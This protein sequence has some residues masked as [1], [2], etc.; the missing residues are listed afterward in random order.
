M[1]NLYVRSTDGS[2]S[3]NGS[4]WALAKATITGAAAIDVAGDSI[5]VSQS[6]AESTA[7]ALSPNWAGNVVSP[8]RIVCVSDAAEPPGALA[9][10]ASITTTGLSNMT[11]GPASA[12]LY[13]YGLNFIAGSGATGTVTLSP[14]NTSARVIFES[15]SFQLAT[16]GAS[17]RISPGG[18][19]GLAT[20]RNCGFK[21][22]HVDQGFS[23]S[24]GGAV[25][26]FEGG[27]LLAGGVSPTTLIPVSAGA[28]IVDFDGFDFSNAG[29]ALN[30]AA[31]ATN[32]MR[33][34]LRNCRLPA[35]WSGALNTLIPGAGALW[36]MF[37]CDAGDTRYRYRRAEEFGTIQDEG[38]VKRTGGASDGTD[39][40]SWKLVTRANAEYPLNVLATPE[41]V[42]WNETTGAPITVT[43]DLVHDSVTALKDNEIWLEVQYLG[44][45]GVPLGAFI[46]D[47]AVLL[48]TAADQAS[49][50]ATWTT[51][52]LTNPN[53][54]KLAVT[55]TPQ[56][57]GF[58]HA[59]V[60]MAKASYTAYVDP[61]LQVS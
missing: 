2:D 57:K 60:K 45:S 59:V 53:K 31:V 13:H 36:E 16:T 14:C 34:T 51:T 9:T 7:A 35:S 19:S 4:T 40:F 18:N 6:H 43:V 56:E 30:L 55:F 20:Y 50:S 41:L 46:E 28:C 38:T 33:V 25:V 21:F 49:S 22:A 47:R 37:N 17:A 23:L 58:L 11:L 8:S 5:Y 27:S 26:R 61:M 48:A 42:Q 32:G 44:T 39:T 1:A 10:G 15:C 52:G 29:A 24:G 3:D 12:Y 54:Q